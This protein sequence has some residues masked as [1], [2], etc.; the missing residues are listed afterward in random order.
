MNEWHIEKDAVACFR[1]A[2]GMKSEIKGYEVIEL[3]EQKSFDKMRDNILIENGVQKVRISTEY[4]LRLAQLI[5]INKKHMETVDIFVSKDYPM[6]VR[7]K[8]MEFI[9]APRVES[10]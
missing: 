4:L 7:N 9:I 5:R 10:D 6:L 8:G 3:I 1:V 2:D